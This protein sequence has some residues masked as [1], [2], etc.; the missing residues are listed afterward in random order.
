MVIFTYFL[1]QNPSKHFYSLHTRS[2]QVLS[3][4]ETILKWVYLFLLPLHNLQNNFG[5]W[6]LLVLRYA[7]YLILRVIRNAIHSDSPRCLRKK[8][9]SGNPVYM[10]RRFKETFAKDVRVHFVGAWY[11]ILR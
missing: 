5:N 9:T 8:H 2:P 1:H 4:S 6:E 7:G 3:V 10:A 11:V